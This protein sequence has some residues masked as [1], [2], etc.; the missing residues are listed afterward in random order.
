MTKAAARKRLNEARNKLRA[1][2]FSTINKA[3]D[4]LLST[5]DSKKIFNMDSQIEALIKKVMKCGT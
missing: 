2:N 4:F 5:T 1:V 3:G